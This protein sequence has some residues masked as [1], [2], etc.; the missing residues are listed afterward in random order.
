MLGAKLGQDSPVV[1]QGCVC[2]GGADTINIGKHLLIL[3]AKASSRTGQM[4][5]LGS[6]T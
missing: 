3:F 4:E 5:G 2:Y 1:T 6:G